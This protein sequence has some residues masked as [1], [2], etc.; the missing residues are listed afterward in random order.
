MNDIL[1]GFGIGIIAGVVICALIF[2][3]N[4]DVKYVKPLNECERVHNVYECQW[5]ATPQVQPEWVPE[6]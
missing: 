1:L 6:K 3:S 2:A 5:V 4:H